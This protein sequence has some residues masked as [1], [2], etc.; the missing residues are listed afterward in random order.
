MSFAD[1]SDLAEANGMLELV[2]LGRQKREDDLE[3]LFESGD[4]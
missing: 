3:A 1:F 4:T 2:K